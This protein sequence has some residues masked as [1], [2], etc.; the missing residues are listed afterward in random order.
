MRFH[1]GNVIQDQSRSTDK[2]GWQRI[3]SPAL[4]RGYVLALAAG[5]FSFTILC[6]ALSVLSWVAGPGFGRSAPATSSP[7]EGAVWALLLY[8]P[9]HELLHA[10]WH[11]RA[12]LSPQ[13]VM[14]M[15]PA[16]LQFGVYYDGCMT[17]RRW[18]LMRLAPLFFLSVVPAL[19]LAIVQTEPSSPA[20][21]AFLEV[22]LLVNCVGGGGDIVA[23]I[24]VMRQVPASTQICFDGGKAYWRHM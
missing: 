21:Q 8:I 2:T 15:W 19:I 11:P 9:A 1:L 3:H 22:L 14:V 4:W 16:K 24:W 10:I 17:R 6:G 18:L 5:F 12:G 13:T 20:L 23:A 7:W